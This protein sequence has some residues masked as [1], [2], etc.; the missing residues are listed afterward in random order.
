MVVNPLLVGGLGCVFVAAVLAVAAVTFGRRERKEVSRS[1]EAIASF[2]ASPR[3]LRDHELEKPFSERVLGPLSQ[4]FIGAGRWATPDDRLERIRG[5]LDLAGNPPGWDV[6]RILGL[7][8]LGL[9][10]GLFLGAVVPPLLGFGLRW[11]LV[12]LLALAVL[13]WF[14]PTM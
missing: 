3:V 6:D 8:A 4:R 10:I 5:R 7:K 11:T 2:R 9:L 1:L 12:A 14:T 13:G